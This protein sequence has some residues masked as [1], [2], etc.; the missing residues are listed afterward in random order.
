MAPGYDGYYLNFLAGEH[1]TWDARDEPDLAWVRGNWAG[2]ENRM[3]I[4]F[5]GGKR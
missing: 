2:G 5:A 3:R 4:P 1:A